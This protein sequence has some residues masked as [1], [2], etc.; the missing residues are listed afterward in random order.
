[1]DGFPPRAMSRYDEIR[2]KGGVFLH[3]SLDD[4]FEE[5]SGEVEA[6]D[7]AVDLVHPVTRRT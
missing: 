7:E 5:T 1:M 3:C 6:P 2:G 4:R